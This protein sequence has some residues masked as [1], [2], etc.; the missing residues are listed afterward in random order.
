M[1]MSNTNTIMAKWN[2]LDSM[3]YKVECT[4]SKLITLAKENKDELPDAELMIEAATEHLQKENDELKSF[5]I[6]EKLI[7][8]GNSYLC[9]SCKRNIFD[10]IEN[11]I[12]F[13]PGCGK[14]I[15]LPT[16]SPYKKFKQAN[17]L[18]NATENSAN[19]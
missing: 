3:I 8:N 4:V 5:R 7:K 1:S 14:R 11:D 16:V 15:I 13:C 18:V 17:N 12:R 2:L 9:P 19:N 6:P 10:I